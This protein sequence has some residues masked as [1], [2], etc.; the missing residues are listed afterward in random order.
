MKDYRVN[1]GSGVRDLGPIHTSGAI[2]LRRRSET[3]DFGRTKTRSPLLLFLR[4]GRTP[5]LCCSKQ[6][7]AARQRD[8]VVRVHGLF[9]VPSLVYTSGL[10]QDQIETWPTMIVANE[11]TCNSVE[12]LTVGAIKSNRN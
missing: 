3:F 9:Q 1:R 11:V 8:R 6:I 2:S 12:T 4:D 10:G 5:F 7:V